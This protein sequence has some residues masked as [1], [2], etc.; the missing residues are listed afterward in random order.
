MKKSLIALRKN[1]EETT[2]KL[3]KAFDRKHPIA[4]LNTHCLVCYCRYTNK[5][6]V[7]KVSSIEAIEE[8]VDNSI[9]IYISSGARL[10]VYGVI[11]DIFT[12]VEQ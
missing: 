12:G 10:V 5:Q 2:P 4:N 8:W 7:I 11:S 1:I 6:V 3:I 9:N